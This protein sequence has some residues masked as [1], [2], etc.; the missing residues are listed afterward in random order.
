M[1]SFHV[2]KIRSWVPVWLPNIKLLTGSNAKHKPDL[3]SEEFVFNS[4]VHI[5]SKKRNSPN[6]HQLVNRNQNVAYSHIGMLFGKK[7]E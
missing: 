5:I 4:K 1:F 3:Q 6:V 2:T 7:K